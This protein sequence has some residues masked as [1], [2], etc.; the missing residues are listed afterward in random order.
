MQDR[1]YFILGGLF[2]NVNA[3]NYFMT[4]TDFPLSLLSN[5][6]AL[7]NIVYILKKV[8]ELENRVITFIRYKEMISH[9]HNLD[10]D[11][12]YDNPKVQ[13]YF[14]VYDK[15]KKL[16]DENSDDEYFDTW[17]TELKCAVNDYILR[18]RMKM[19]KKEY[20][21]AKNKC[22]TVETKTADCEE[23]MV[24]RECLKARKLGKDMVEFIMIWREEE[25]EVLRSLLRDDQKI[26]IVGYE[27]NTKERVEYYNQVYD[28][29]SENSEKVMG[30]PF[31]LPT[32]N[33][34]TDGWTRGRAYCLA[35]RTAQGKTAFAL[36]EEVY[37]F[38]NSEM[39]I[40]HFNLEMPNKELEARL[41]AARTETSFGK[42]LKGNWASQ[43]E[44]DE[45]VSKLVK[46]S[47]KK[48]K[49][50]FKIIDKPSLNLSELRYY[51]RQFYRRW[52][53]NFLLVVDNLNIMKYPAML[54]KEDAASNISKEFHEIVKEY[55]IPGFLLCQL[56]RDADGE[57]RNI[58]PRH[59]RDSDKIPDHMD[60]CF[61][62]TT[63]SKKRKRLI[64]VKGR[65]FEG[66]F[67]N[68]ENR[69]DIMRLIEVPRNSKEDDSE[70]LDFV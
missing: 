11:T 27:S 29:K 50:E 70:G 14:Q 49:N 47:R 24:R 37:A 66:D 23:C 63:L 9:L 53:N 45:F 43:E 38:D 25:E 62:I 59:F 32:L 69:L 30:V 1:L 57:L 28:L 4:R 40:L 7:M 22:F 58:S 33:A 16:Y 12:V 56:N 51:V 64:L 35:G 46:V 65:S 36:Q 67:I 21:M 39:N 26:I 55:N 5:N 3:L 41:D 10:P 60:A 48:R 8:Y 31:T 44:K 17:K 19:S 13:I 18:A 15:A 54:K 68:L 34:W 61:A 2:F 20:L 52:G 6:K 42:V